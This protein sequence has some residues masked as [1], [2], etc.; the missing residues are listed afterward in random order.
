MA[1]V[2]LVIGSKSRQKEEMKVSTVSICTLSKESE[3]EISKNH[4]QDTSLYILLTRTI[5][6]CHSL[7]RECVNLPTVYATTINYPEFF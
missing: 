5:S 7:C 2:F 6:P 3:R 4:P 1:T